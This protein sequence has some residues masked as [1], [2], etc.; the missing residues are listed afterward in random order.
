MVQLRGGYVLFLAGLVSCAPS[1]QQPA[2]A[3]A[4]S[5]ADREAIDRGHQAV[6]AALRAND[7]NALVPLLTDD[8]VFSP[9]NTPDAAGPEGV[10]AWCE[11][12]VTQMKITGVTVTGREVT[13]AG[14]WAIEHGAFEWTVVPAAGGPEQREQ[15]RFLAIWRRLADGS[16][17]LSRDIWNSSVPA[18]TAGR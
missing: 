1:E 17:K 9:P 18:P 15:G 8:V 5:T 12:M 7:C 3:A 16:W 10:R 6:L 2:D 11:P 14:D 13:V 4:T